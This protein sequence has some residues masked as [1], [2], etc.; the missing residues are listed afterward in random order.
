M[1]SRGAS[2][3]L[4]SR[5]CEVEILVLDELGTAN[6]HT[7]AAGAS[8]V[9]HRVLTARYDA[10]LRTSVTSGMTRDELLA[11]FGSGLVRRM[12]HQAKC[13]EAFKP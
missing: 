7:A 4:I 5:A 10:G 3:T 8:P 1:P 9:I 11:R 13:L 2:T 12:F 6:G